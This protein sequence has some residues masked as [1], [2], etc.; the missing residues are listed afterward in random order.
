MFGDRNLKGYGKL[1]QLTTAR[2]HY[3][4]HDFGK[5]ETYGLEI[6][7]EDCK[8]ETKNGERDSN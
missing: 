3:H 5:G 1:S 2:G 4:E 8:V 6:A 7:V